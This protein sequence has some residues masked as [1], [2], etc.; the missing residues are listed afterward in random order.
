MEFYG[1]VTESGSGDGRIWRWKRERMGEGRSHSVAKIKQ[2]RESGVR[3]EAKRLF[4][5]CKS[6]VIN[7]LLNK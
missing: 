5:T 1:D 4:T 2:D 3:R 6:A 7:V